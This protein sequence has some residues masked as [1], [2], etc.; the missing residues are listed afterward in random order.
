MPV[1]SVESADRHVEGRVIMQDHSLYALTYGLM[2]GIRVTVC[3]FEYMF[4]C[5]FA[6]FEELIYV[7]KI[8]TYVYNV[9][10]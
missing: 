7:Y 8:L 10:S 5:L 9:L 6:L 4:V 1:D 2:L 3:V